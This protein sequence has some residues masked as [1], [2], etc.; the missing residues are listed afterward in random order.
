MDNSKYLKDKNLQQKIGLFEFRNVL[1]ESGH[2]L[3]SW[4]G[5]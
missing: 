2:I 3:D 1:H 4:L 5:V